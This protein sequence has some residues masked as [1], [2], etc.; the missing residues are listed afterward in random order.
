MLLTLSLH[1]AL[2]WAV[3]ARPAAPLQ[4]STEAPDDG[5][6]AMVWL[7]PFATRADIPAVTLPH[8]TQPLAQAA[9]LAEKAAQP[10]QA[11]PVVHYSAPRTQAASPGETADAVPPHDA[12]AAP[13][14]P[15]GSAGTPGAEDEA[16]APLQAARGA[17][18]LL[19]LA[20]QD[21]ARADRELR[22]GKTPALQ[23]DERRQNKLDQT[24]DRASIASHKWYNAPQIRELAV[25]VTSMG[26]AR[27]YEV[28]H[29]GGR[30]CIYYPA[31]GSPYHS[32]EC[33]REK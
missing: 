8:A 4:H 11:A 17:D 13:R 21:A 15:P 33:P 18:E 29:A 30:Y 9:P 12:S 16:P 10:L 14:T 7:Q 26:G 28:R 25:P 22:Q 3:L 20:R 6:P 27:V 5:R 2:L 19:R 32:K 23:P 31:D 24:F 1:L